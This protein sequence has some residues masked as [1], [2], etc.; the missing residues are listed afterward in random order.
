MEFEKRIYRLQ[1][2]G[3]KVT[4]IDFSNVT[5]EEHLKLAN[6]VDGILRSNNSMTYFLMNGYNAQFNL[7]VIK[8][9]KNIVTKYDF[10]E[11][12]ASVY[13]LDFLRRIAVKFTNYTNPHSVSG[14][15]EKEDAE[16][17]LIENII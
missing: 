3:T 10:V 12:R 5:I 7:E 2:K 17:Y 4:V 15:K 11:Y 16:M 8:A 6:T 9:W 1:L 13:G 14:F